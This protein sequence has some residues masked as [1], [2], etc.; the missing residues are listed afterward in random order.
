MRTWHAAIASLGTAAFLVGAYVA[1]LSVSGALFAF[2]D[3]ATPEPVAPLK[4]VVATSKKDKPEPV[5]ARAPRP[6]PS[7]EP[8]AV[9][10]V[11][12]EPSPASTSAAPAFEPSPAD[13]RGSGSAGA[14]GGGSSTDGRGADARGAPFEPP[15]TTRREQ[16]DDR[17]GRPLVSGDGVNLSGP[18]RNAAEP[19][20]RAVQR[21]TG[22]DLRAVT[23]PV[24]RAV[25]HLERG[26][27]LD[28]QGR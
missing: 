25:D 3:L 14:G 27:G 17:D 9:D 26:L 28:R 4:P 5:V 22:V 13:G 8:A 10:P 6:E 11:E 1:V 20:N 21:G 15:A 12:P 7:P 24:T 2:T 18:V 23:D 16:V 19:V